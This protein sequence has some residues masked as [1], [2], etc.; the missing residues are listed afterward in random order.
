[1]LCVDFVKCAG[2][3][4]VFSVPRVHTASVNLG[5]PHYARRL[6]MKGV[7]LESV[8]LILSGLSVVNVYQ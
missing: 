3:P 7:S 4:Q 8:L 1:M 6:Y 2:L 5:V